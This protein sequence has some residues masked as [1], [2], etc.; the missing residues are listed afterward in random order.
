MIKTIKAQLEKEGLLA[1]DASDSDS[2][3]SF[4]SSPTVRLNTEEEP[5]RREDEKI[6]RASPTSVVVVH[7]AEVEASSKDKA[8]GLMTKEDE[9]RIVKEKKEKEERRKR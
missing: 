8:K 9:E 7:K 2:D 3:L 4:L 6:P 1:M 5:K